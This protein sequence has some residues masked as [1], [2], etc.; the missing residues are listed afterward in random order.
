[1]I[2]VIAKATLP[3][4]AWD[5]ARPALA[6]MVRA[7]RE[8]AGCLDYALCQDL[9]DPDTLRAV[10]HWE[11]LAALKAHFGTPHM[12]AFREAIGEIGPL[13]LTVEMFEA[14]PQPLPDV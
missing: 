2:T 7:T 3:P 14:D 1:M 6:A 4:G 11:S 12:A 9:V 8:E 10:E 5:K 13:D